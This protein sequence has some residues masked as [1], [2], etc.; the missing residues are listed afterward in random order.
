MPR[1]LAYLTLL[2]TAAPLLLTPGDVSAQSTPVVTQNNRQFTPTELTVKVGQTVIFRNEDNIPHHVVSH[3]PQFMFDLDLQ[4]PGTENSVTFTKPGKI[5]VG[6][7]LHP[8]MEVAVT[9]QE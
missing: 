5:I 4:Q 2:A 1:T 6:C 3:T 7:D 9:V 8:R